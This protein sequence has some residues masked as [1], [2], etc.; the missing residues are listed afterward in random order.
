[1]LSEMGALIA[2]HGGSPL[3]APVLQEVYATD[4]TE[5]TALVDDLCVGKL[6]VIVLQTGVGTHALFEAAGNRGMDQELL[7]ALGRATV[8]ARSPKPA[9]VLRKNKV[10]IDLMPSEPFTSED[11]VVA[12]QGMDFR[13]KEVA[14]Q[15]YGGPNTLLTNMLK[16]RG[17][18][19]REVSLYT[20]GL[21]EDQSP[22][23]QF[24]D[25]LSAGEI[26]AVAFTSQPQVRNLLDI[27]T[28]AGRERVLLQALNSESV[29][30]ASVGPVCT[31]RL[32]EEDIKVDVEPDHPHMGNLVIAL[33]EHFQRF[34][35]FPT[36][37]V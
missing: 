14:I 2:R 16:E 23:F 33:A 10:H 18:R 6:Q 12:M 20:W 27:A 17:A 26:P 25:K 4:T 11:M 37:S 9:A 21:P 34:S 1:M 36:R 24:I 32:K 7:G 30:V 29:V 28:R 31:R 8:I 19:V 15:A 13:G 35:A 3:A 5:V 22:V